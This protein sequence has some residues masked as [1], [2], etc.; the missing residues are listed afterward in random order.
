ME[1][2][3]TNKKIDKTEFPVIE[4]LS[5]CTY[6]VGEIAFL[7]EWVPEGDYDGVVKELREEIDD[8]NIQL[9]YMPGFD[10]DML[11]YLPPLSLPSGFNAT[12]FPISVRNRADDSAF[13][14]RDDSGFH[15]NF[16]V[17]KNPKYYGHVYALD[18]GGDYFGMWGSTKEERM[19]YVKKLR[20]LLESGGTETINGI[21]AIRLVNE[22]EGLSPTQVEETERLVRKHEFS[23]TFGI[24]SHYRPH[25]DRYISKWEITN[26][27][28]E[29]K[30]KFGT[31][32][33]ELASLYKQFDDRYE[34]KPN[35][36]S[37]VFYSKDSMLTSDDLKFLEEF[38]HLF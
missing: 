37:V 18:D 16:G 15:L 10:A 27:G 20:E 12:P 31:S 25:R 28:K 24:C 22:I 19:R 17:D 1:E 13:H 4:S 34:G 35:T 30:T 21:D 8:Y 9:I 29:R 6:K 3:S 26:A 14:L 36:I 38:S 23:A 11:V 7:P 5:K 32:H 2:L 33:I